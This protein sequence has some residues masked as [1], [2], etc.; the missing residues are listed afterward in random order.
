MHSY[1][2]LSCRWLF[3][4]RL[5]NVTHLLFLS[6]HP[7]PPLKASFQ[8]SSIVAF[9]VL[10]ECVTILAHLMFYSYSLLSLKICVFYSSRCILL[11][12]RHCCN[13]CISQRFQMESAGRQSS[14]LGWNKPFLISH[15]IVGAAGGGECSYQKS[16]FQ[17]R[18]LYQAISRV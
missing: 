12:Q 11:A 13:S 16:Q 15:L 3:S 7:F 9:Q 8:L 14:V 1:F 17:I 18:S 4:L 5:P 6:R 2:W 10:S